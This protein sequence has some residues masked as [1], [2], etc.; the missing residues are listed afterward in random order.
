MRD[1]KVTALFL[2]VASSCA[3]ATA[4]LQTNPEVP[5]LDKPVGSIL[6]LQPNRE[7]QTL[8]NSR[9][10]RVTLTN[11]NKYVGSYY[12]LDA[13]IA[14]ER[15]TL[16]LE[17]PALRP[18]ELER[19]KL[20]L[21]SDGIAVSTPA[22]GVQHFVL[23]PNAFVHA[24]PLAAN[25][26]SRP[27]D[28][29]LCDAPTVSDVLRS[30]TRAASA[31]TPICDGLVLVRSQKSGAATLLESTTDF[32]RQ[33]SFGDWLLEQSKPYLI[34]APELVSDHAGTGQSLP[35]AGP[36]PALVDPSHNE[37]SCVASS[38]GIETEAPDRNLVYGRW[39]RALSHPGVFVSVMKASMVEKQI[40]A[41]YPDRVA[42][43]GSQDARE[44]DA[45]VYA[46]AFDTR[47]FRFGFAMGA[48]HPYL[49]WSPY[50]QSPPHKAPGPDGFA[51]KKP[52]ATIG[53]VAPNE[54]PFVAATFTGGFKRQH[55]AFKSGTLARVN[56]GSHF[57]FAEKGVVF[58][59]LMP[60]L[61]TAFIRQ[62]GQMDL[63]SWPQE[64][65][66]F[67]SSMHDARQNCV[68]IVDGVDTAG[69]TI[70]GAL[71]NK[72]GEGAWSGSQTGQFTTT[73][74]GLA[75]QDTG[76]TP[77]VIFTYF[78]GATPNAM[79]RVFQ[80]YQCRYAM[81][82]DMNSFSACFAALY[83]R[84]AQRQVA[85]VEYL[86]M[87]MAAVGGKAGSLRFLQTNDTRDFFYVLRKP[88]D[89]RVAK[90]LP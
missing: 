28:I 45:L 9:G 12:I 57:G 86:H 26:A 84:D 8:E 85:D 44:G 42:R 15:I 63:F 81:L 47:Q 19:P 30:A 65:S 56:N 88:D 50:I 43:L 38:L 11:L 33:A 78:T 32:L 39:Y 29:Q 5:S 13:T 75:I 10:D 18:T 73:R 64:S 4:D 66:A 82:L 25:D 53:A 68:A 36:R 54:A 41:S 70:P 72:W 71:V 49:G 60:G 6:E 34:P 87:G 89:E 61:A 58:S 74:T 21:S 46:L 48:E 90:R 59:R 7:S 52:L 76:G 22:H 62:N 37:A 79:A 20:T 27:A 83:S 24:P 23:W 3:A 55:G 16:H 1:M 67:S 80:A 51:T 35:T 77:F 17:A 69:M 14:N 40:L 31:F 2:A